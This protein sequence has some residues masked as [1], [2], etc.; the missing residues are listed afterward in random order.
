[1]MQMKPSKE[2]TTKKFKQVVDIVANFFEWWEYLDSREVEERFKV[3]LLKNSVMFD[4]YSM[5][6]VL[7][8]WELHQEL[9]KEILL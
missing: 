9:P 2:R 5:Q 7:S 8:H 4:H 6:E 1:M 3:T